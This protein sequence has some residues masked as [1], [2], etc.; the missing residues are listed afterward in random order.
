MD[1]CKHPF[2]PP[3]GDAAMEGVSEN[4]VQWAVFDTL[5]RDFGPEDKARADR[6]ITEILFGAERRKLLAGGKK[7]PENCIKGLDL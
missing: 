7:E 3:A 5:C 1:K 4:G 2:V 6:E